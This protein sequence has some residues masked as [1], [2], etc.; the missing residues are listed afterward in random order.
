M[1]CWSECQQYGDWLRRK[2]A[3]VEDTELDDRFKG[4]YGRM[5]VQALK[6]ASLFAALD[7]LDTDDPAP[8]LT[9]DHW[10]AAQG[11]AEDWRMS[12]HRLTEQLDRSGEA[13]IERR[14]QDRMLGIIRG[15]GRAGCELRDLY[16]QMHITAKVG[17]QVAQEL[18]RAG[19]VVE[20]R[21][22]GAEG[23][24]ALESIPTM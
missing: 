8:T 24:A 10:S 1:Q 4:I 12:A 19:L 9:A 17:R 14:Q 3:P 20:V 21:L 18:V 22:D 23:Y 5:H 7:W 16:R 6:L 15:K 11:I 2:C 13:T